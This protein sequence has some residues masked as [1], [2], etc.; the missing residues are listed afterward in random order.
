MVVQQ[1]I[2]G[3]LRFQTPVSPPFG[4]TPTF[5]GKRKPVLLPNRSQKTDYNGKGLV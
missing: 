4:A 1:A 3:Y 2:K 5:P